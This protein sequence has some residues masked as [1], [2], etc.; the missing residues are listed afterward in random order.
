MKGFSF[1]DRDFKR[2]TMSSGYVVTLLI[3]EG[4]E[5]AY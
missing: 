2:S 3:T 4:F 1:V 5:L